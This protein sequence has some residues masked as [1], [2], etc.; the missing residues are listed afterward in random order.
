MFFL[1]KLRMN[2]LNEWGYKDSPKTLYKAEAKLANVTKQTLKKETS[3]LNLLLKTF[4]KVLFKKINVCSSMHLWVS[5]ALWL[6]FNGPALLNKL[7]NGVLKTEYFIKY[8]LF[9]G[10]GLRK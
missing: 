5:Y 7:H 9:T 3:K 2:K 6:I 1:R 8:D 10:Y 4:H